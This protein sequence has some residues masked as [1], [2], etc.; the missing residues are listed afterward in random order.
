M[1]PDTK[2][3][4]TA[5][6]EVFNFDNAQQASADLDVT[7]MG[8]LIETY[9]LQHA[10]VAQPDFYKLLCE[11]CSASASAATTTTRRNRSNSSN[12]EHHHHHHKKRKKYKLYEKNTNCFSIYAHES[13]ELTEEHLLG[14]AP[15]FRSNYFVPITQSFQQ[16]LPLLSDDCKRMYET[17]NA[18]G[19]SIVSEVVSLQ[20][21]QSVYSGSS[22]YQCEMEIEY[23]DPHGKIT[24]YVLQLP[25]GDLIGVSVTR[26]MNYQDPD[27]FTY[28]DGLYL[29]SKKL[30]G[31][32]ESNENFADKRIKKQILHILCQSESIRRKLKKIY[33]SK[34]I[35]DELKA[36]TI[37]ICTVVED[38]YNCG[39][40][41]RIF[42]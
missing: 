12:S 37:V 13:Q 3:N 4:S 27:L 19:S 42:D 38:P 11:F 31:C 10:I 22:L 18:G 39:D 41:N 5:A 29:L 32:V 17:P 20:F 33:Y 9:N 30:N 28:Q 15:L 40:L 6:V 2:N 14:D 35:S 24:D 23:Q 34:Y 1:L 21:L 8:N 25:K 7:L 16:M 36:D 26:G